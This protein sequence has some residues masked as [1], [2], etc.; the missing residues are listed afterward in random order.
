M[1]VFVALPVMALSLYAGGHIHTNISQ[2][3]FKRAIGLALLGSGAAL[4]LH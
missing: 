4:L 1:L 2:E 3:S